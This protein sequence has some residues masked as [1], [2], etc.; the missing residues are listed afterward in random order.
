MSISIIKFV[1]HTVLI[2]GFSC[3]AMASHHGNDDGAVGNKEN[4]DWRYYAKDQSVS[5]YAD[6]DQINKDTVKDLKLAWSW[7]S[8]DNKAIKANPKHVPLGFKSSPIKIGRVL[9]INTSLGHVAA[10]DAGTGKQLW[11]FDTGTVADGRP[12][13]MGFNSR[14]VSYWEKDDKRRIIVGTNNAYLW[15][16]DAATGIPDKTF[17][18][19][20]RVDLT[21]GL[22][23]KVIRK[24]Y[25]IVAAP[26]IVDNNVVIGGVIMDGPVYTFTPDNRTD[27][28]PG[29]I[30]GIDV[31]T[32]K[33]NWVFHSIPQEGEKGNET[34]ENGS[35]KTTGGTNVWSSMSVDPELGYI[36]LPFGTPNNDWYGGL[37]LGDNLYSESLVCLNAKTGKLVWHYQMVHHGLWDYD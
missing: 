36:Y 33:I 29:H 13:N 12:A 9:Y 34:W 15:S 2:V 24:H 25:S 7:D 3:F 6:L 14:G 19:N 11:T 17:G 5:K 27:I 16:L 23:R 26:A 18:T 22:G 8:P 37:R 32:G 31:E 28:H 30:R 35:W 1:V 20:G 4:T 21:L 10:I